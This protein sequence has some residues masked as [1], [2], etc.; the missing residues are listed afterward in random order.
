MGMLYS[1]EKAL[2]LVTD[3]RKNVYMDLTGNP[4]VELASYNLYTRKWIRISGRVEVENSLKIREAMLDLY[5]MIRQEY[6]DQDEIKWGLK[7]R[8]VTGKKG[9]EF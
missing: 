1:D 7:R 2:F 6:V 8:T 9:A 5:P 4:Q 3:K